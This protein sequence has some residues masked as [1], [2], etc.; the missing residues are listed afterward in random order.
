MNY[1]GGMAEVTFMKVNDHRIAIKIGKHRIFDY[2]DGRV[3]HKSSG[4]GDTVSV[5]YRELLKK[6]EKLMKEGSLIS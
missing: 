6:M 1:D 5:D 2:V 4:N 3:E